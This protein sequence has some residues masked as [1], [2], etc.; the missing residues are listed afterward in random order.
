MGCGELFPL[1]AYWEGDILYDQ[2]LRAALVPLAGSLRR[3]SRRP[4]SL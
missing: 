3:Q 4:T 2:D 1:L